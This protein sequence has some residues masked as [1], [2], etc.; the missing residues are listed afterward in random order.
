VRRAPRGERR[1]RPVNLVRLLGRVPRRLLTTGAFLFVCLL[2][3][4]DYATGP[5]LSPLIFYAVPV[6]VIVW[7][8]GRAAAIA[9]S[10]F[11]A[12][13][14]FLADYLTGRSYAHPAIPYWNGMEKLFFFL[15]LTGLVSTLKTALERE[16]LARQEFLEKE[17]RVAEEV[18]RRLLPQN[19]PAL[20][21]LE[22]VGICQP[23]RGVGGDYFDFLPLAADRIGLAVGDVSGK[24]LSAALLM[25]SLQGI[26]RSFASLRGEDA[27]RIVAETNRQLCTLV[28]MNRFVTLFFGI[29]DDARRELTCVNAGHNPPLLLRA[30]A[31]GERPD[32]LSSDGTVLGLFPQAEWSQQTLRLETGDL[33]LAF[34]DGIPE[35]A[36]LRDEEFGEERLQ[37]ALRRNRSR[38]LP[39]L[40]AAILSEVSDFLEGA[41]ASDDLTVV[42]LRG[43]SAAPQRNTPSG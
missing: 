30:E 36:N 39:E 25:A 11:A 8:A 1:G 41:P 33:L 15:L 26:L 7:F 43:R 16:K 18:Q 32:R 14:W 5:D 37:A 10:I 31:D 4:A 21:T 12:A 29:Y 34:T 3:W 6:V 2:W 17:L 20:A 40:C 19:P 42:A 23:A 22:C 38:P 24:G 35:A 27:G 28:E 9:L 13:A